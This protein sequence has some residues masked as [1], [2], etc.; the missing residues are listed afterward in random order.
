MP[1]PLRAFDD[2]FFHLAAHASDTRYL[3]VSDRDRNKFLELLALI[4]T[5]H[6][7]V[8]VAYTLMGN[9][10]HLILYTPDAR[11]SR[12][13]QQLQTGYSRRHNRKYG[14]SAHLFRAHFGAR[15]ITSDEQL[16]AAARYL[17]L[18]PVEAGLARHPLAWRWSS[19]R[20]HAGLARARVP[21][22]ESPLR[23]AFDNNPDWRQS[24]R[25]LIET[26]SA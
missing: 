20:V 3:F 21:L 11:V 9:H 19:A 18:N 2:G 16:L 25:R 23:T 24:Y 10:Y 7:L 5:R 15:E 6:E 13:M 4:F 26:K 12:A 22:D 17:A 8:A 1:R 14:R